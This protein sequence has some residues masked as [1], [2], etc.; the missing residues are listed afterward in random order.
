MGEIHFK[1]PSLIKKNR[2][3]SLAHPKIKLAVVEHLPSKHEALSS[4]PEY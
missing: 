1:I 2:T 3:G 4:K